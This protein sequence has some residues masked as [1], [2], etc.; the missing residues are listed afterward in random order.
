MSQRMIEKNGAYAPHR[1]EGVKVRLRAKQ[2]PDWRLPDRLSHV[3]IT[4]GRSFLP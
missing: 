1:G 2:D 4:K 3:T